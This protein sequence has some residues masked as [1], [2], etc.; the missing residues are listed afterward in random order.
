MTRARHTHDAF[1]IL[2]SAAGPRPHPDLDRVLDELRDCFTGIVLGRYPSLRE[3]AEDLVQE[4]LMVL[5]SREKLAMVK[6]P[7]H[8][9]AWAVAIFCNRCRSELRSRWRL[10]RGPAEVPS[11]RGSRHVPSSPSLE[12]VYVSRQIVESTLALVERCPVAQLAWI[13]GLSEAEIMARLSLRTR[14]QV[15]GRLKRLRVR[16]L[17]DPGISSPRYACPGS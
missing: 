2:W 7:D 12:D 14:A 10:E 8:V 5:V 3:V 4:T 16:I 1:T 13:E 9:E 11:R 15:A 17:T 6:D